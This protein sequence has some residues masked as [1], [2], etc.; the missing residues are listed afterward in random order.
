MHGVQLIGSGFRKV[1]NYTCFVFTAESDTT[2]IYT[3]SA[4]YLSSMVLECQVDKSL[5][6]LI[7][8]NYY[9]LRIGYNT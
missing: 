6:T 1:L 2:P 9:T 5:L 4:T 8:D 7:S 3:S